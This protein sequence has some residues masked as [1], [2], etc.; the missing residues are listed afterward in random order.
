MNNN[1]HLDI[2]K[3][4]GADFPI[5]LIYV[6]TFGLMRI[7]TTDLSTR[8]FSEDGNYFSEEGLIIDESI[9][10]YVEPHQIAYSEFAL[11]KLVSE[12]VSM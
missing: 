6:K 2:I 8:L 5:R 7:S 12:E 10:F 11:C 3:Y 4:D 9:F 1:L